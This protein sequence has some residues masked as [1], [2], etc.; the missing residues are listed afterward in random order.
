M[1][2]DILSGL[3]RSLLRHRAELLKGLKERARGAISRG[4]E[5]PRPRSEAPREPKARVMD[6]KFAAIPR[7]ASSTF[8]PPSPE[9]LFS[10]E[11][12]EALRRQSGGQVGRR[13]THGG[14]PGDSGSRKDPEA[15][16]HD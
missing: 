2:R 1:L 16:P 12:Q 15:R 7:E 6:E 14:I 9:S 10:R 4:R 5:H 8:L 3:G 11:Q 13:G